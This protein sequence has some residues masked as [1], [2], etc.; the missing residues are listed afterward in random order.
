RS[1]APAAWDRLRQRVYA[2]AGHRCAICGAAGRLHCHEVWSY[3]DAAHTQRLEGC[4]ALCV[5]CH[6]VKHLGLAGLLA[7]QGKLD[8]ERVIAH[9]LRVN[10]CDRATFRA[11][12]ERAF[13]QWRERSRYEWTTDLGA[14]NPPAP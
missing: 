7:S 11:H 1:R 14:L 9:F 6:H 5:W 8:Y 13:A 3:D 12:S 4:V 10:G 2:A